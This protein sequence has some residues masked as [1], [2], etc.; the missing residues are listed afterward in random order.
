MTAS[1]DSYQYALGNKYDYRE[2]DSENDFI[3]RNATRSDDAYFRM[4]SPIYA[5]AT[6]LRGKG[7]YKRQR[8]RFE[9]WQEE[10]WKHQRA[11]AYHDKE[12]TIDRDMGREAFQRE[13]ALE[14]IDSEG[15]ADVNEAELD[16]Q[17]Q[18]EN[19]MAG[20]GRDY[21]DGSRRASIASVKKG[22]LGSSRDAELQ[23]DLSAGFQSRTM[24]AQQTALARRADNL[25]RRK[26]ARSSIR[27]SI[28]SG[29]PNQAAAWTN[30][31]RGQIA[32][33]SREARMQDYMNVFNA[34]RAQRGEDTSRAI[35]GSASALAGSVDLDASARGT[36][37]QGL[38]GYD[39]MS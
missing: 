2:G 7:E 35:G 13:N 20:L 8:R 28:I 22:M 5:M 17:T 21:Q 16:Y 18:M 37:G 34:L 38:A 9:R 14:E 19:A 39:W 25:R 15:N 1:Q 12:Y 10:Q 6:A 31:A 3:K 11:G 4:H 36:G 27:R 32:G 33:A 24:D 30:D 26:S 29:D 23:S